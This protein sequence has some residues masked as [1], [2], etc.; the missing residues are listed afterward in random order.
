MTTDPT[1]RWP[2]AK[3]LRHLEQHFQPCDL[4]EIRCGASRAAGQRGQCGVDDQVYVYNRL[5][6][7]GE[8]APLVPSYA[9]FLSGCSMACSFCSEGR[10][11][12][13]PFAA[14]PT[15][16][17][18]LAHKIA[19]DLERAPRPIKNLNF[20][21]GEPGISLPWIARL[22][23]ELEKLVE[24]P[25]PVLL[26]TNGYLTPHVLALA[27]HLCELFVVDF[28]FGNDRCAQEVANTDDY[29]QVLRRNLRWLAQPDSAPSD[30][31]APVMPVRL[32]VRHLLMPEHLSCCAAPCLDWLAQNAPQARVNVMPAFHPF[33]EEGNEPWRALQ[34]QEKEEGLALLR[35]A[36]LPR[37]FFDGRRV[38]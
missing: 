17:E 22:V 5:I 25:P 30:L 23:V 26:N 28:K 4:C 16:P 2:A 21:G 12:Q 31:E 35:A 27:T 1:Q 8:E 6:H 20:V 15:Q 36:G 9:V 37:A 10:H 3:V 14:Q 11:L 34:A 7:M 38:R 13:P 19:R 29:S 18:A 24:R 32:W 33:G